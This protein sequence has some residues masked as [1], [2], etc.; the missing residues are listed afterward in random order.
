MSRSNTPDK[1][2][3]S[4]LYKG[5]VLNCSYP[6]LMIR[7]RIDESKAKPEFIESKLKSFFVR[8]YFKKCAAGSSRTMVKIN[9]SIIENIPIILPPL[10]EQTKIAQILSTWD[11]AIET[12]EALI[13]KSTLQKK[14]LMQQLLTG[15]K[16][17]I[18]SGDQGWTSGGLGDFVE[19]IVGG[20]TPGRNIVEFWD[21][22]IP[23]VTV[24]DLIA[25]IIK[26]AQEH[27][28]KEG[29]ENSAGNL[30]PA[31][32]VI[33]ATRMAVGKIVMATCDVVINQD[34]KAIFP[35]KLLESKYLYYW[36]IFHSENI[37]RLGTGSTVK[38]VQLGDIRHLK[39]LFPTSLQEQ[40]KIVS[41]FDNVTLDIKKLD[42]QRVC[43]QQEKQALMQQLLTGKRRVKPDEFEDLPQQLEKAL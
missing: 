29:L 25:P 12:V 10:S 7:F 5:E 35:K 39:L 18:N 15:E 30:I 8:S 20:G 11:K 26:G 28:T 33:M 21:G 1:V 16:R 9:K 37:K 32:T 24:K 34:L 23:W 43:L 42:E 36:L 31:G 6:D 3:R 38:G 13:E 4:I 41:I 19:K 27:I 2:G 40:Q 14:A 17:L 22:N